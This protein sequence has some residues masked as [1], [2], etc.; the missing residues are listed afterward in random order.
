MFAQWSNWSSKMSSPRLKTT[1]SLSSEYAEKAY[2]FVSHRNA[3]SYKSDGNFG[4]FGRLI[5][6]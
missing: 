3:V 6:G 1:N 5:P 4:D 2:L